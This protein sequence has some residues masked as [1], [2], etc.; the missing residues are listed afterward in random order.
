MTRAE[1]IE[2][3]LL[4]I[5]SG[6]QSLRVIA[7]QI[8]EADQPGPAKSRDELR[9]VAKTVHTASVRAVLALL[10]TAGHAAALEALA[11]VEPDRG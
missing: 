7:Y 5:K 2:Q 1:A 6:A 11:S 9:L 8:D 10:S 4:G 3:C